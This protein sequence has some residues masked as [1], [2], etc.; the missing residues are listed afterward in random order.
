MNPGST[1]LDL[2]V[3]VTV[4]GTMLL[5]A[6]ASLSPELDAQALATSPW[7]S[8]SSTADNP[9]PWRHHAFPGKPPSFYRYVRIDGRDALVVDSSSSASMMRQAV[10]IEPEQLHRL[11]ISWKVP[12][13]I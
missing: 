4:I 2:R 8:L 3:W 7:A 5:G 13:L 12:A 10:R 9:A 6:C 11:R 1:T